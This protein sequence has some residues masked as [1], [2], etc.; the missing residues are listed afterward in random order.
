MAKGLAAEFLDGKGPF[1]GRLRMVTRDIGP[2]IDQR[3]GGL[4]D[5]EVIAGPQAEAVGLVTA[6]ENGIAG[7]GQD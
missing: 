5:D 3:K 7:V 6:K 1:T 4:A 2:F